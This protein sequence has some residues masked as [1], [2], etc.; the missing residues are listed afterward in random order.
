MRR[1]LVDSVGK[2]RWI[3]PPPVNLE[4]DTD[5]T[6]RAHVLADFPVRQ[7]EP[8]AAALLDG[9]RLPCLTFTNAHSQR[10]K[11]AKGRA[12]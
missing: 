2:S 5:L 11:G 1:R 8:C 6:S 12:E 10:G 4:F 9:V 7:D 3:M